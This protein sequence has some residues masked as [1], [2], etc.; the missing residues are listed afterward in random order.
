M[1]YES[2]R[3][4]EVPSSQGIPKK[5]DILQ[6][7]YVMHTIVLRTSR[8]IHKTHCTY[9]VRLMF[10]LHISR[11]ESFRPLATYLYTAGLSSYSQKF[12]EVNIYKTTYW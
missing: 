9:A 12:N 3:S 5:V 10:D 7:S 8:V 1:S 2:T 6:T 4:Y 11:K